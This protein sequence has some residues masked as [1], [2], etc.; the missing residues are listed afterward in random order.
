[1]EEV[2][3]VLVRVM[4]GEEVALEVPEGV[5]VREL[6]NCVGVILVVGEIVRVAVLVALE[7]LVCE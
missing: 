2:E 7:V 5:M 1:M 6:K 4:L 3:S